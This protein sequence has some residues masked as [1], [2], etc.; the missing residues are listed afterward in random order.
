MVEGRSAALLGPRSLLGLCCGGSVRRRAGQC[1]ASACVHFRWNLHGNCQHCFSLLV[2]MGFICRV[3]VAVSCSWQ[4]AFWEHA[5]ASPGFSSPHRTSSLAGR[6]AGALRALS[7][8]SCGR[9]PPLV[10]GVHKIIYSAFFGK[11]AIY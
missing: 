1:R 6:K 4:M 10:Q 11:H 8:A 5:P 7:L 2:H 9:R 3:S